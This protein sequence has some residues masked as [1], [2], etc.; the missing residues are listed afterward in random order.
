M[1][2]KNIGII[3][4][5]VIAAIAAISF[6]GFQKSPAIVLKF[7]NNDVSLQKIG[8][9]KVSEPF[10]MA[11]SGNFVNLNIV[12]PSNSIIT[13]S[14]TCITTGAYRIYCDD[15]TEENGTYSINVKVYENGYEPAGNI[16]IDKN[17]SGTWSK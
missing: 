14:K 6:I 2:E 13:C 17:L 4:L 5:F 12:Q 11:C 16:L 10:E 1:K 15:L 3:I 7:E 8:I 9:V